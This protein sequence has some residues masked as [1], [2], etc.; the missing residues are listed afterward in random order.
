MSFRSLLQ[1]YW[2][3]RFLLIV[4]IVSSVFMLF[5]LIRIDGIVHGTL[6]DY[7]LQFSDAWAQP[8]WSYARLFYAAFTVP[9]ILSVAALLLSFPRRTTYEKKV[10]VRTKL[11][12]RNIMISCP[13][14]KKVF[15]KP[16]VVRDFT[17]GKGKLVNVCPYCNKKFG[18]VEDGKDLVT[19][20]G[21]GKKVVQ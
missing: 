2:F 21:V 3:T 5:S 8:Y 1:G 9:T 20:V 19:I 4:W 18:C 10:F 11:N 6:Y 15:A 16:R 14:C 13:F 17:E 7:G 12:E